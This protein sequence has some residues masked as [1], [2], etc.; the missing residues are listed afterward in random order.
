M[1]LTEAKTDL[2]QNGY[3]VPENV[4]DAAEAK[5]LDVQARALMTEKTGYVKLE[6]ALNLVPDLAPLC[7]HPDVLD[8]VEH[9]LG[10]D[11]YLVNNVCAMWCQPGSPDGRLHSDWP[12]DQVPDPWP[13]WPLLIQIMWMLTD[14][15]TENGTTRVVPGSHRFLRPPDPDRI[16]FG[17]RSVT[18]NRGSV[19]VWH[20]A[21]W[22]RNGPNT[23]KT[24]HRVGANIAYAPC[25]IHRP[26]D[27]WP[28]V[29]QDLYDQFP[30]RLQRLLERS[31]ET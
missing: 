8:V 17:E 25:L 22:H 21:L 1:S 13:E 16:Y 27:A 20:G 10:D 19:L 9:A 23:T 3:C 24:D 14:F 29:S 28:L 6:G 11:F 12:L 2:A 30:E 31:K 26:P 5:R 7:T 4:L 18:G 15:T